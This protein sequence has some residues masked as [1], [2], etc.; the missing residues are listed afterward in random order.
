M[1]GCTSEPPQR[2]LPAGERMLTI[3]GYRPCAAFWPPM[4]A[5]RAAA[6]SFLHGARK[7]VG[8]EGGC[9]WRWQVARWAVLER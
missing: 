3:H 2:W 8:R 6:S 9:L 1:R 7:V 4:M 5:G